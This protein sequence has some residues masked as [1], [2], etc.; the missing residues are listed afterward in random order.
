MQHTLP[1][2]L[3]PAPKLYVCRFPAL[4]LALRGQLHF[5]PFTIYDNDEQTN[6]E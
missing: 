5:V 4:S 3:Y 2:P 1:K 6:A